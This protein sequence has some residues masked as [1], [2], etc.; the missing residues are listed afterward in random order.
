L[1]K[2]YYENDHGKLYCGDCLEIMPR[3]IAEGVKVDAVVT[4]PP[5]GL[6]RFKAKDGGNSKKI[7]S[8]GDSD[9]NWNN[10]KPPAEVFD[11][12]FS[13]SKHQVIFGMNN[14]S[15]PPTEY[16]IVWDKGQKMPSFAECELAWCS[17]NR[18]AKIF[19]GRFVMGKVHPAEKP[20]DLL[21]WIASNYTEP[22]STIL[23]PFAGSGTTLVAAQSLGR[24]WIGIEISPEYCEIAKKRLEGTIRQIDG[25]TS[26]FEQLGGAK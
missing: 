8:F 14:F 12:I 21:E 5:Y 20:V 26:I 19:R 24:K 7:R 6:E 15:L 18:P 13:I 25:Q 3:L 10:E 1:I 16:Y 17:M 11:L 22:N 23:D 4:D 2:P 9:K